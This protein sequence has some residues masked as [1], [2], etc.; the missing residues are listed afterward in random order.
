MNK[1]PNKLKTKDKTKVDLKK[2]NIRL[3][4]GGGW[5]GPDGW[6]IVKDMAKH[7]GSVWK[8]LNKS[9]KRIAKE[10]NISLFSINKNSS[11]SADLVKNLLCFFK[12]F[13]FFL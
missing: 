9:G 10:C 2:F 13:L 5:K 6:K 1:I 7:A 3:P 12:S 11:F 4:N 8:L